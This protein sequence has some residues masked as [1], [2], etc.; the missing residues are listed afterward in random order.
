MHRP[1]SLW[2]VLL[3]VLVI[4]AFSAGCGGAAE[5]TM[6]RKFFQSSRLGDNMTLATIATVAFD[7]TKDGQASSVKVVSVTPE[8]A[9]PLQF[10]ELEQARK[11]ASEAEAE[12]SKKMKEYQDKN[13][14]AINRVIKIEQTGK[15]KPAGKDAE[16]QASWTKWRD[17]SK[18]FNSKVSEARK[19][20]QA[21]RKVADLSLPD[22]DI[23]QFDGV[24]EATKE[25]TVTANVRTPDGQSA[26]KTL[27]LTLQ[28]VVT[29]D[30]AGKPIEG[31]WMIT[32]LKEAAAGS[33]S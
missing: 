29:K 11:A 26:K 6:V 33:G 22:H 17:D 7:P 19:A 2:Y 25:V 12:F 27:V 1:R 23:T 18:S 16:V 10:K 8:E 15:G 28:R 4:V 21:E 24:I 31:K 9:R 30:S 13:I 32:G 14:E 5:E 3:P 20:L